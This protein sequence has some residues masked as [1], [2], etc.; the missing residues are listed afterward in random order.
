MKTFLD[1]NIPYWFNK[2]LN[3]IL[4]IIE[5]K[6]TKRLQL[7]FWL[8]YRV[9]DIEG[10]EDDWFLGKRKSFTLWKWNE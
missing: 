5:N 4:W 10:Y 8:N 9:L 7:I 3:I 6:K 2:Q 1:I